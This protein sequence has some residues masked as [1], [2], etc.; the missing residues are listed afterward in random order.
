VLKS[1]LIEEFAARCAI[2]A[3]KSEKYLK[4]FI[5]L[6]YKVTGKNE[7]ILISGFG[8]FKISYH[9]SRL[10]VN[11][12]NPSQKITI[13]ELNTVNNSVPAKGR[14]PPNQFNGW[15]KMVLTSPTPFCVIY[16]ICGCSFFSQAGLL[17]R[18]HVKI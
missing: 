16:V 6:I 7:E 8:K 18:I 13:P 12:R 5:N 11:P 1:Q 4:I 10:G 9:F 2:T 3:S 17:C 15:R 14:N